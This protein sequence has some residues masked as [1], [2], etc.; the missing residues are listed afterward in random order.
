MV[1]AIYKKFSEKYNFSEK[2]SPEQRE[3]ILL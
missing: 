2:V 1:S 3:K